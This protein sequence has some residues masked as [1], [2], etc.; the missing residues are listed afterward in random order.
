MMDKTRLLFV[1]VNVT[2]LDDY[3]CEEGFKEI[4]FKMIG[5]KKINYCKRFRAFGCDSGL[6]APKSSTGG[7]ANPAAIAKPNFISKTP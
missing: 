1:C 4:D 2:I 5:L 7:N 3:E 6:V